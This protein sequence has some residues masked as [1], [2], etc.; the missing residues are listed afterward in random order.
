MKRNSKRLV[1]VLL[2]AGLCAGAL[3]GCGAESAATAEAGTE[4]QPETEHEVTQTTEEPAEA[5][6]EE[7]WSDVFVEPVAG[8]SDDFI[9]GMDASAVLSVEKSG[10]KY[11]GYD[12]KEQD[13]F[14]TLAESG[15]N[16]IR[17]RVWND[18]YDENG[19]GYGGGDNDVATAIELGKRATQYGMKVNIDF[20]YSDFWADPKRQHAPKAWEGMSA[21]EK[22]DALYD[23]TKESLTQILDAGVDVGMV[24][25]G[26]EINNGMSG[27]TDV[28]AVME[29]LSAGSRAVREIADSYGKD[30]QIVLHYTNIE[31]NEEVDTMAANLKEYGVDYDIFGLSYYPF[32]DGTNENMQNVAKNIMDRYGK[33]VV[34]AETSYCYTE[35]DGDGF[36]NSFDG[37][38]DAVDGYAPTVQS[39]ATM[40]RDIC[41]A[42]NEVGVLGVFYWEGTWIPVGSADQDNSA[43]W[44]KYGSGWASSYS[45]EYDPDDAGLYYGGCSWDNQA[46]FDFT[47]HPLPSLNVFRYLKDGHT[48]PLAVDFIPQTTV[49]RDVGEALTLPETVEVVYNDRSANTQVP[50]SWDASQVAA[51]DTKKAGTY[52]V[53]GMLSVGTAVTADVDVEMV[54]YVKNP[55]FEEVDRS[56]WEIFYAGENDPTDYQEK[57]D[58]AHDGDMESTSDLELYAVING[59][60][61]GSDAFM[62]TTWTDW[63]QPKV[64]NIRIGDGDTLTIGVR[65]KCNANSWGTIDDFTLNRISD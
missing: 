27:E 30:I 63:K 40:I 56:M 58:D 60:E 46:M 43:L 38:E 22:A 25:V 57:A 1:A 33:K 2:S 49:S 24:Q 62:L 53:D 21:D 13:V 48:V 6:A 5:E 55:G 16:Y 10:A 64:D 15:V 9:R 52:T 18:P 12:G 34:I 32:W 51:I 26:N 17:L 19:N 14:E 36:G 45:A 61:I 31:D 11:Y 50:V 59:E 4:A 65:M 41:A 35:K 7:E 23:F 54:N 44:E 3:S 28:P 20:H 8:I 39:Q 47:G 37:I 42:A 29:L